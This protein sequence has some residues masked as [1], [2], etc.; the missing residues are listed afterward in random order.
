MP[1]T[2]EVQAVIG[3]PFVA[4]DLDGRQGLALLHADD[5]MTDDLPLNERATRLLKSR[6]VRGAAIVIARRLVP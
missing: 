5:E 4:T 2:R 3:G 1:T 6:L